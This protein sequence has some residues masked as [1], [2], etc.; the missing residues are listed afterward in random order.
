MCN[1][2]E[3]HGNASFLSICFV[4][5]LFREQAEKTVWL[6]RGINVFR[7]WPRHGSISCDKVFL[8]IHD[9]ARHKSI[10]FREVS[11]GKRPQFIVRVVSHI[12]PVGHDLIVILRWDIWYHL[13]PCLFHYKFRSNVSIAHLNGNLLYIP[14][15]APMVTMFS[16]AIWRHYATF[17]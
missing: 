15:P 11:I 12:N 3:M 16:Y 4:V 7:A 9:K 8:Q 10:H 2:K 14:I 5:C 6:W 17:S 13:M 1:T